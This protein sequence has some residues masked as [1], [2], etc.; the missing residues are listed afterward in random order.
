MTSIKEEYELKISFL[1]GKMRYRAEHA[2]LRKELIARAMGEHPRN[3]PYIVDATAGLGRDS[4]ILATL[5]FKITLLERAL[6]VFEA[7]QKALNEAKPI[8]PQ[9]IERMHLVHTDA[10]EW[11]KETSP[12]PDIICLDPMF[13]ERKKSASVK[14]EMVILQKLLG[15]DEDHDLL[16]LTALANAKKRVVVKRPKLAP[17][18]SDR[19]PNFSLTGKSSRLDVYLIKE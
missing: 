19:A 9:T 2:G 17:N 6:P 16:F 13:P 1:E 12:K 8:Y 10:I 5:G 11:L 15:K 4:F 7:L 18:C 14:K 3:Q